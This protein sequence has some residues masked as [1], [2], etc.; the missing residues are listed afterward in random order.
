VVEQPLALVEAQPLALVAPPQQS[1]APQRSPPHSPRA[2]R[3]SHKIP[4]HPPADS[5]NFDKIQ[6][7]KSPLSLT[8]PSVN[9]D[10]RSILTE[11]PRRNQPRPF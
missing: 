5:R 10:L 1:E 8:R 3:T 4:A 2:C 9:G 6:P 11:N 7:C